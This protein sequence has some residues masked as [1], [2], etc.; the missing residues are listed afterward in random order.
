LQ[1]KKVH[2]FSLLDMHLPARALRTI[3]KHAMFP[4]GARVLVAVSG[5]SDSVALL[6]I[7]QV[8]E[9]QGELVVAGIGHFNHQLRGADADADEQ[10]CRDA[11][12][13]ERVPIVV[14]RADVADLATRSGRSI[15]DMARSA[16]Y[17]FLAD[18]S[19]QLRA[20]AIAV[21][22]SLDDQAETFLLRLIRGAGARGLAGIRPRADKVV[23][24]L[25]EI[26]RADLRTY[27]AQ[28][29]LAFREDATNADV[30]IPRNRVRL[31][32]IPALQGYSP[33]IVTILA[34]EAALAREDEEYLQRTAIE[35]GDSIVLRSKRGVE[36][37][38]EAIR[39]LPPALASRVARLALEATAA[40]RFIGFQ[41]IDRLLELAG[42]PEGA[43]VALP[44]GVATRRGGRI[45]LG[46]A[47]PLPFS[48]SFRFPLSIPGEVA[49]TGWAVSAERVE[50]AAGVQA[51]PARGG[52]AVVPADPLH[53]PLAVRTRRRGDRFRPL[54]MGGRGRKLQDFLVDRKVSRTE[55]D[56]LPLVV[57]CDDRIVWVVG[58]SVA[59]DFRIT[60][61]QR[62]V[63]LL[64]A[65]RLGGVG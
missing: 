47:A 26:S 44:G 11:A 40:G 36:L 49:L 65:R 50:D 25:L 41:H 12:A 48:N 30:G 20:D 22:H 64:K 34:R 39:A 54:G 17:Q 51:P 9:Q 15:E 52:M 33:A 6:H 4:R 38:A 10:F 43:S 60:E 8:L 13:A 57:D 7:L 28:H 56:H 32:L 63:I 62:G 61:P 5:G 27:A 46:T 37:E 42:A 23:R 21:G 18:A 14:G 58:E 59:E 2:P 1:G 53:F 3:R 19:E 16:R 31:E 35:V 24:P 55:R 45:V 29:R